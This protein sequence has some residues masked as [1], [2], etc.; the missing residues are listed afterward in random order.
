MKKRCITVVRTASVTVSNM[1]SK[2]IKCDFEKQGAVSGNILLI[3]F[4]FFSKTQNLRSIFI[5]IKQIKREI[6]LSF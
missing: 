2:K 6:P 1:T 4:Y 3:D 5:N